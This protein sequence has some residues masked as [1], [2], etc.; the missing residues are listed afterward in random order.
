[1]RNFKAIYR[2]AAIGG[3]QLGS[4]QRTTIASKR[5]F[6]LRKFAMRQFDLLPQC[7]LRMLA[8]LCYSIDNNSQCFNLMFF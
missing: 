4:I 5:H 6:L 3:A 2:S 8:G 1:M 7:L